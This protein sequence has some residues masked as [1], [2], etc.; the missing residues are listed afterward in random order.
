MGFFV[1]KNTIF[2]NINWGEELVQ[3]PFYRL[4]A[5]NQLFTYRHQGFWACMDTLKEKKMFDDMYSRGETPWVL[6][7]NGLSLK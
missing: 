4:I 2:E 3:E 7:E 6:W 5:K 1:F